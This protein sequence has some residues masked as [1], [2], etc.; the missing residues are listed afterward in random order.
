MTSNLTAQRWMIRYSYAT[1]EPYV[2]NGRQVN[3]TYLNNG[4]ESLTPQEAAAAIARDFRHEGPFADIE[5][6]QESEQD[7]DARLA[8]RRREQARDRMGEG[9]DMGGAN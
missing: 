6:W 5:I 2:R 7:R 3:T 1:D 8:T 4:E 9:W